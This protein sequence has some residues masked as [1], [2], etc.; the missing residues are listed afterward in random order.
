MHVLEWKWVVLLLAVAAIA[1][2]SAGAQSLAWS[3]FLGTTGVSS[4]QVVVDGQGNSYSAAAAQDPGGLADIVVVKHDAAGDQVWSA[5][6]NGTGNGS[7][8]PFDIAL[9][10]RAT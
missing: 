5:R 6:F 9:D 10:P 3:S 1:A 7:D 4:P 8:D 2:P